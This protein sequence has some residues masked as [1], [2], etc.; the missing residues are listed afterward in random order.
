[1]G[2]IISYVKFSYALLIFCRCNGGYPSN[3]FYYWTYTGVP[4]GGPYNS[5][6]GCQP[7]ALSPQCYSSQYAPACS[8][9]CLSGYKVVYS[10][11]DLH[12]GKPNHCVY[13]RHLILFFRFQLLHAERSYSNANRDHD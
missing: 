7:Y 11:Y 8:T 12:K 13:H 4:T 2:K 5:N 3:A 6:Q 10:N 1:M 9:K